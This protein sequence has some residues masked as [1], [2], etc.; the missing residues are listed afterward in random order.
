[1]MSSTMLRLALL[2]TS[3]PYLL[4]VSPPICSSN[5]IAGFTAS[6]APLTSPLPQSQLLVDRSLSN[7]SDISTNQEGKCD[8]EILLRTTTHVVVVDPTVDFHT[9]S[10]LWNRSHVVQVS[11]S[12][13]F[14]LRLVIIYVDGTPIREFKN[15]EV[16]GVPYPKSQPMRVYSSI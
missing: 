12:I 11:S 15:L 4:P 16:V 14:V 13:Y 10:V 2:C 6:I 7:T 3:S 1:M 9:C 8:C 5:C